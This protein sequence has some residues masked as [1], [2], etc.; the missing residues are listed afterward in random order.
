MAAAAHRLVHQDCID[1]R[2]VSSRNEARG[3]RLI[4]QSAFIEQANDMIRTTVAVGGFSSEVGNTT[5]LCHL[6]NAFPGWEAIKLMRG[7]YRPCGKDPHACCVSHRL[8]DE[9]VIRSGHERRVRGRC[10]C[11]PQRSKGV[12]IIVQSNM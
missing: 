3:R 4:K 9:P 11:N 10:R 5:L 8:S 6:L 12:D 1:G 2:S 7:H